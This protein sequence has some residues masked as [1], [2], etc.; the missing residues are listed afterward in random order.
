MPKSAPSPILNARI[1]LLG[2][3]AGAM[4]VLV[5]HQLT[6]VALNGFNFGSAWRLAPGVRPFSVPPIINQMFWGGLWGIVFAA[7]T[8][9]L[10]RG[11][12][13]LIAGFL[14]GA[15]VLVLAG[16]YLVPF[17]KS[18]F[19]VANLRYGPN[20]TGWWR[21]PVINGMWGLGAALFLTLLRVRR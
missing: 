8:P 20:P 12:G 9:L 14:F 11:V 16:W 6:I 1:V 3:L 17:V 7:L 19:G 18:L 4:A 10:P 2:F 5:F 21:G 13:Y 15:V